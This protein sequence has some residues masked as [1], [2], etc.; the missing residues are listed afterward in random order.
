MPFEQ[1]AIIILFS[2]LPIYFYLLF[3]LHRGL[4][5][6]HPDFVAEHGIESL[7][8]SPANFKDLK[9]FLGFGALPPKFNADFKYHLLAFRALYLCELLLVLSMIINSIVMANHLPGA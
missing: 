1:V 2:S 8:N 9:L 5:K 4:K 7:F 3:A 6:N